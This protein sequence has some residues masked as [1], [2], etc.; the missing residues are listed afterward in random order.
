M[1]RDLCQVWSLVSLLVYLHILPI[2]ALINVHKKHS[3]RRL[4]TLAVK[5]IDWVL[6]VCYEQV[7][8]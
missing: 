6:D 8:K 3:C 2:L 1:A 4:D 7:R 5:V